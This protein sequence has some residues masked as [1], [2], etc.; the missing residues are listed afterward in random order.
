[1]SSYLS[2]L[3]ALALLAPPE[4]RSLTCARVLEFTFRCAT[5]SRRNRCS[6]RERPNTGGSSRAMRQAGR[7][8]RDND[9]AHTYAQADTCCCA[10]V[11]ADGRGVAALHC[12]NDN[13]NNNESPMMST[14]HQVHAEAR[15]ELAAA[16]QSRRAT[17]RRHRAR[18]KAGARLGVC[19]SRLLALCS[20]RT[21]EFAM[22]LQ[23]SASIR[24]F[25]GWLMRPLAR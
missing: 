18:D 20:Q 7:S 15:T 16:Q 12:N 3:S 4:I 25:S 6:A 2:S 9:A 8:V 24:L 5:L 19:L 22:E 23:G 13:S 17:Q 21:V 10:Q 14:R 11:A 1:M